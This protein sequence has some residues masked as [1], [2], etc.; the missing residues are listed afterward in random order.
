MWANNPMGPAAVEALG[1][2]GWS[3]GDVKL[4][5]VGCTDSALNVAADRKRFLGTNYWALRVVSV[6]MAGQSSASTGTA[7]LL[8]GH[9]NVHR[10]SPIVGGDRFKLDRTGDIA[11]LRALGSSEARTQLP[12][13]RDD[14]LTHKANRF[15]PL[16]SL[17][18]KAAVTPN[19]KST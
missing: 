12:I 17:G 7:Q 6:M 18:S 15:V 14:F 4:L 1:V 2:L 10:I 3:K 8:L 5:S 13:I 9:E 11:S 19:G 16:R